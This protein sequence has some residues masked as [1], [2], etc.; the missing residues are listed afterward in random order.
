MDSGSRNLPRRL[1]DTT[2]VDAVL[3]DVLSTAATN[4]GMRL[5]QDYVNGSMSYSAFAGQWQSL[6]TGSAQ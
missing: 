1:K 6:L 5:I 3:D 4:S 2:V